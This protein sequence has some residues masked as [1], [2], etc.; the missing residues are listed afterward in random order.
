M[1]AFFLGQAK[2]LTAHDV[3]GSYHASKLPTQLKNWRSIVQPMGY[4]DDAEAGASNVAPPV[5]VDSCFVTT[6]EGERHVPVRQ[7]LY[8]KR[9]RP[10]KRVTLPS[11]RK[12]DKSSTKKSCQPPRN[13]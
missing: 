10:L 6:A 1:V 7:S 5:R 13:N 12:S 3:V 2:S 8:E 11:S 4:I 9:K